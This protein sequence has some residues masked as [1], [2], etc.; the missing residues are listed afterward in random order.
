M[1]ESHRRPAT[2]A[3]CGRGSGPARS[4]VVFPLAVQGR[5]QDRRLHRAEAIGVADPQP[6]CRSCPLN[7]QGGQVPA[8]RHESKPPISAKRLGPPVASAG[9]AASDRR[10][11][12]SGG[13]RRPAAGP[14]SVASFVPG[15][16]QSSTDSGSCRPSRQHP[17]P[18]GFW[19]R[20]DRLTPHP[21]RP[22]ASRRARADLR[23]GSRPLDRVNPPLA[24]MAIASRTA[25]HAWRDRFV[26]RYPHDPAH[27]LAAP[28]SPSTRLP[29]EGFPAAATA[30]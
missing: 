20:H 13:Q 19:P 12:R 5:Q 11:A 30:I 27:G 24:R 7:G 25:G 28:R 3:R 14:A 21:H 2:I 1:A 4:A 10:R 6:Q 17:P 9:A 16:R 18:A 22:Q 26:T 29:H 23:A 8:Q 15:V